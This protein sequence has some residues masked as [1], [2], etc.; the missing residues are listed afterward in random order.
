MGKRNSVMI[1]NGLDDR[2]Y[3]FEKFLAN[4]PI[5]RLFGREVKMEYFTYD[6]L[7]R[8]LDAISEYG[9]SKLLIGIEF[10]IG[11]DMGLLG[12]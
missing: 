1:L 11:L 3:I 7:G 2:L 6:A 4:K 12:K 10:E 8:C 9:V 5:E